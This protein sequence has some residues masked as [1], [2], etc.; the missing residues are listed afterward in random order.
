MSSWSLEQGWSWLLDNFSEFQ[1]HTLGTFI[2]HE[3]CYWGSYVPFLLL[4]AIPY[5][6]RWKIQR[7][8]VNDASTQWNCILGVLRNHFLL[9]LPLII[10]THPFFAWMGTRDE[11]PLP[12]IGEIASQV[13]LFFV[14][15]DFI[16]YWGHRALHTPYLYRKVH[17]VHHLHSSPFGITAEYAHPVEVVFLGTASI[18]GPMLVGP[19]LLTLW[20]YLGLRLVQTVEAHSGYDFPWSPRYWI[21]FY[22]GAEFHDYHH[23]IYSGNYAS[24]FI[25]NDYMFGTDYAY[26]FYKAKGMDA[27]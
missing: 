23:K 1:L 14:I 15:E 2:I 18:A 9:V 17:V 13:F 22:G 21:P 25:W 7:D 27:S 12:S 10:V 5:F 8:K 24:S 4:D 3:V 26:H 16:F 19:H 11:L 6:R 20:I